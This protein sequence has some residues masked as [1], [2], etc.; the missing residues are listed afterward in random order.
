MSW[1]P[2]ENWDNPFHKT[3][4]FGEESWNEQPEFSAYEAGAD[5][6]LRELKKSYG[7]KVEATTTWSLVIEAKGNHEETLDIHNPD[8]LIRQCGKKGWVIFIPEE[9]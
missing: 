4:D 3:G 9:D 5:A 6:M 1:R 7:T 8:N 2:K